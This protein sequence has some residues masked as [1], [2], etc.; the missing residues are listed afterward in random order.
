MNL[1]PQ[2]QAA[3]TAP[4]VNLCIMAGAGSGKT[5]VIVERIK[6]MISIGVDPKSILALTYTRRAAKEMVDRLRADLG[7]QAAQVTTTTIHGF[8]LLQLTRFGAAIGWR[9]ESM[10]VF[11]EDDSK[12]LM[13]WVL[14]DLGFRKNGVLKKVKRRDIDRA[15]HRL[16]VHGEWPD[17]EEQPDIYLIVKTFYAACRESNTLTYPLILVE[18]ERLMKAVDNVDCGPNDLIRAEYRHVIVDEVQDTTILQW[19]LIRSL[20]PD[21]LVSCGDLRQSIFGFSGADPAHTTAQTKTAHQLLLANNYRSTV[22]IVA[23]G[24]RCMQDWPKM[25][26]MK[27]AGSPVIVT[28]SSSENIV[29]VVNMALKMGYQFG[30]ICILARVHRVLAKSVDALRELGADIYYPKELAKNEDHPDTAAIHALMSLS[31]NPHDLF[32][33]R[34][35]A[36]HLGLTDVGVQQIRATAKRERVS[37]IE[38]HQ[39]V[40]GRPL[41]VSDWI[42]GPGWNEGIQKWIAGNLA[43]HD[44]DHARYLQ[45]YAMRD[46]QANQEVIPEGHIVAL[47]IHQAKGLEFPCVILIG[48]SEGILPSQMCKSEGEIEEERRLYYVAVTRAESLLIVCPRPDGEPSRFIGEV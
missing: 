35:V 42:A 40:T 1:D 32:S 45:W 38:A 33:F 18:F 15:M 37:F 25:A 22:D 27:P 39:T 26:A 41:N 12:R 11:S 4:L 2:Q 10:S 8:C 43:E 48:A 19:R 16:G 47:S 34:S 24:N 14:D 17:Q 9:P 21:T 5:R 29:N 46:L 44:G 13:N 6:H 7:R 30:D 23:E 36:G 20:L 28:P 3:V 31:V